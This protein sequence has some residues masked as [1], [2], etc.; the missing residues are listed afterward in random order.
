MEIGQIKGLLK[1][2]SIEKV[3]LK[4]D[5]GALRVLVEDDALLTAILF[6]VDVEFNFNGKKYSIEYSRLGEAIQKEEL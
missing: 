3:V 4:T 1:T 2:S 5:G 6:G